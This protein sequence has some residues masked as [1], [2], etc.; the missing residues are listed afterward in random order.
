MAESDDDDDDDDDDRVEGFV[1]LSGNNVMMAG[2][3][4]DLRRAK[5]LQ[6][7]RQ[8]PALRAPGRQVLRDPR[9]EDA[10]AGAR[11]LRAADRELGE[12]QAELGKKQAELGM[13]QAEF[14]QKQAALG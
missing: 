7:G 4:A 2:S 14:G 10:R 1:L 12:Q 8:G 6:H 5:A 3:T 11:R 9:R 13:K